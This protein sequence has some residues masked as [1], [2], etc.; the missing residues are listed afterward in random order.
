MVSRP[1]CGLNIKTH[2]AVPS[3]KSLGYFRFVRVR[4]LAGL[5]S[6]TRSTATSQLTADVVIFRNI[7]SNDADFIV[8]WSTSKP[9][10]TSDRFIA[11]AAWM[12]D[13]IT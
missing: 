13:A 9:A 7:S 12:S 3:D 2:V 8:R 4:G 5:R 11:A 1:L 6:A 10:S